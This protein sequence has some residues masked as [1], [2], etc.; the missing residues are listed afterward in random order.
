MNKITYIFFAH[1]AHKTFMYTYT[2][3]NFTDFVGEFK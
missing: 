2:F 1:S 3:G